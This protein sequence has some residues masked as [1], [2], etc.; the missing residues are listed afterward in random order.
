MNSSTDRIERKILLTAPRSR[1]WRA[2]ANPE[3][4]G[5]WF[6][7]ALK[8]QRFKAGE[9]VQGHVTYPGYEHV[10]LEILIERVEPES[11]LSWRWHPAAIEPNVDYSREP[12]TLVVFELQEV[13]NGTL[14]RVIESGFDNVPPSRRLE[15]F[16]LNS[17]GWD[18]QMVNISKHVAAQ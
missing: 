1:V 4:F 3:E 17:E 6:G 5:S 11:L 12:M 8:G 14:L 7:V 16:R 15:A 18:E 13:Q 2:L 10:I 9:P